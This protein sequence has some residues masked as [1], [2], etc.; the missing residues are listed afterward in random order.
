MKVE[1]EHVKVKDVQPVYNSIINT[2]K[3]KS[4]INSPNYKS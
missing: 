3:I 2:I 1:F 4:Y